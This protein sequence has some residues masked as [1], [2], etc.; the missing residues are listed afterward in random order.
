MKNLNKVE[1]KMLLDIL[2]PYLE[3]VHYELTS[4]KKYTKKIEKIIEK[5]ERR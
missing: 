3:D 5:L 1:K 2:K 4:D